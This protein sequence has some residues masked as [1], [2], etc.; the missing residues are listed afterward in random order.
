MRIN[1]SLRRDGIL[2]ID[3]N[4]ENVIELLDQDELRMRYEG[5]PLMDRLFTCE[6]AFACDRAY[7]NILI[8]LAG[9]IARILFSNSEI[10]AVI[11]QQLV[12][13]L[14]SMNYTGNYALHCI[15]F[16]WLNRAGIAKFA[17]YPTALG[18]PVGSL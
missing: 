12:M 1:L 4:R 5:S 10:L 18:N 9:L 2:P 8:D 13:R 16:N 17:V 7:E 3:I 14:S 6:D 11:Y 15:S